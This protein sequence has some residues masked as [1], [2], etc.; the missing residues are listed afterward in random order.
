MP[1]E[2][3]MRR[4]AGMVNKLR[5]EWRAQ[6]VYSLLAEKHAD[7]AFADLAVAL[8]WVSADPASQ[9]PARI[10]DHG[11]WWLATRFNA[12]NSE[13]QLPGP[14]KEPACDRAGHEH[15]LARNCRACAAERLADTDAD[16]APMH[17]APPPEAITAVANRHRTR[18]PPA[19]TGRDFAQTTPLPS[20][21]IGVQRCHCG[22]FFL[23]YD[24][25][26]DA[27]ETVFG[28]QPSP[29]AETEL[30]AVP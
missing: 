1:S 5:P 15:E 17:A 16:D 3:E 7:R 6:S 22:A 30:A 10:N 24:D 9:T 29:P 13:V 11:P 21:D 14:G 12:G 8:A 26:R 23:P 19:R 18:N 25:G 28:H 27:H 20:P 2:S 4:L